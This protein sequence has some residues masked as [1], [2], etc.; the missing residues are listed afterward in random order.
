MLQTLNQKFLSSAP[1]ESSNPDSQAETDVRKATSQSLSKPLKG[2]KSGGVKR[3]KNS[4]KK[5]IERWDFFDPTAA[6][7]NGIELCM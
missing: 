5:Q 7:V 6:I 3:A 1:S 2:A 4:N